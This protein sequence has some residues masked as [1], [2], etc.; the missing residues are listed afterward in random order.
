VDEQGDLEL[1]N[2]QLVKI[3][4]YAERVRAGEAADVKKLAFALQAV[5]L[6]LHRLQAGDPPLQGE[7]VDRWYDQTIGQNVRVMW[8]KVKPVAEKLKG[9]GILD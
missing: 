3:C 8:T 2:D 9:L 1:T 4:D 5:S 7:E 6:C